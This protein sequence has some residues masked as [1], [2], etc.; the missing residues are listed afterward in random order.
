MQQSKRMRA[1]AAGRM[2]QEGNMEIRAGKSV[3]SG[4]AEGRLFVFSK[5]KPDIGR[6]SVNDPQEEI[7]RYQAA[8][9]KAGEQLMALQKK[10]QEEVGAEEAEIFEA[11]QMMLEDPD[12]VEGITGL[13]EQES[14]NAEYAVQ[15]TAEQFAAVFESMDD[16]YMRGRAADVRDIGAR[17]NAILTNT[18][19][20]AEDMTE[21]SIVLAE[22]LAPSETMQFDKSKLLAIVTQKGS[23]NSHTAILA[24][25]MNIPCL[26][27]ADIELDPALGGH[28]AIVDGMTGQIYI[29]PDEETAAGLHGKKEQENARRALLQ[30][31]KGLPTETKSGRRIHLYSNIGGPADVDAVL[32][33]DSEGVGLFRSEFLYIGKEDYP[34]EEEQ[35]EV[36]KEVLSRLEGRKVIIRTLDIGADK[37]ADYFGLPH[38]ENPAMG[39]R[40]IRICLERPEVFRTQLRAIYRAAVYGTAAIMFPM[41]ISVEEVKRIKEIVAGV[42]E[43]LAAEGNPYGEAELGIMVETPAAAVIADQLAPEVDFF[44]LGTNDLTQYTLAIDRQNQSLDNIYNPHHEAVLRLIE[45]TCKCAHEHGAWCGICGELGADP[46]LTERFVAMGM[47]ELSVSPGRTL[48]LRSRIRGIE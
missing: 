6:R 27:S 8:A 21:P 3:S 11:H 20:G 36:Y 23:G 35:F 25:T 46:E 5:E 9:A 28:T 26:V 10:T 14:V 13:I 39:F 38:E 1:P 45:Y 31:M 37:K 42:K 17:L 4:I 24:R 18:Q 7:A 47:D 33:N 34:T 22:D 30:Q 29:D 12:F 32:E 43:E 19:T 40:A 48:E 16:D 2:D 41:I 44:S 15:V